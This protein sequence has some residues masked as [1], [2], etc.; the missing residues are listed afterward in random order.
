MKLLA[1]IEPGYMTMANINEHKTRGQKV[2]DKPIILEIM[3]AMWGLDPCSNIPSFDTLSDLLDFLIE[4]NALLLG[5]V[6]QDN[7]PHT[8]ELGTCAPRVRV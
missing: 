8:R 5:E 6:F 1:T 7:H 2:P 3:E 4:H